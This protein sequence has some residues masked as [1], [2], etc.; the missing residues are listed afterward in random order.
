M[1]STRVSVAVCAGTGSSL[2]EGQRGRSVRTCFLMWQVVWL[3]DGD[4][5]LWD[6]LISSASHRWGCGPQR[7]AVHSCISSHHTTD[8]RNVSPG[9]QAGFLPAQLVSLTPPPP[10]AAVRSGPHTMLML[11]G[12]HLGPC[13]CH[14]E[15]PPQMTVDAELPLEPQ[16]RL[17]YSKHCPFPLGSSLLQHTATKTT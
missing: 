9:K 1:T 13:P 2:E 16:G 3:K 7:N 11:P 12:I 17:P 14:H 8:T 15:H 6:K 10:F 5:E 4:F